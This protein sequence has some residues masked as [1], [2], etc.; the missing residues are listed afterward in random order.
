MDRTLHGMDQCYHYIPI[1]SFTG[2]NKNYLLL[3]NSY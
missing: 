1:T 2:C 3:L